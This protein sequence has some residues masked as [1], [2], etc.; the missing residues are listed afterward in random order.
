MGAAFADFRLRVPS[1]VFGEFRNAAINTPR[2]PPARSTLRHSVTTRPFRSRP[3]K[4]IARGFGWPARTAARKDRPSRVAV[5]SPVGQANGIFAK[6]LRAQ[7][8]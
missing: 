2:R 6:Y 8:L 7:R 5:T 1:H 3:S 4:K